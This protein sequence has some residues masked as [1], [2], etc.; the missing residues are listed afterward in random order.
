MLTE[1]VT[2]DITLEQKIQFKQFLA[3][4]IE[5]HCTRG[6]YDVYFDYRD[7]ISPETVNKAFFEY[8]ENDNGY[9]KFS[10]YLDTIIYDEWSLWDYDHYLIEEIEK[11]AQSE[12]EYIQ[13][14]LQSIIDSGDLF[15]VLDECG[16]CGIRY[17]IKDVFRDVK[18]NLLLATS[19]ELNYDLS[20]ISRAY[21]EHVDNREWIN[22]YKDNA[23]Q[24]L[25]RQQGYFTK[26]EDFLTDAME[27]ETS[28]FLKSV[29]WELNNAYVGDC[30]C[31]T[32]LISADLD[33][34]DDLADILA[35]KETAKKKITVTKDCEIGL[36]APF[37]GGGSTL[38]IQ[39]EKDFEFPADMLYDV[40]IEHRGHYSGI[41]GYYTVDDIYC[42]CGECWRATAKF[43]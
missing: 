31:L 13:S 41:H 12:P 1:Y 22:L 34:L 36:L 5:E 42:L 29:D 16:Y 25:I 9:S 43:E 14:Q 40:Q 28:K 4:C 35:K 23:L 20:S 18:V 33:T 17:D 19:A 24:Y 26:A 6:C 37:I 21:I 38:D 30:H 2:T 32:V 27:H 7:E 11:D 8:V 3:N 39:L 15:E 10:D